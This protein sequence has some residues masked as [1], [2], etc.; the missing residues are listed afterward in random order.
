MARSEARR[1]IFENE[2]EIGRNKDCGNVRRIRLPRLLELVV[3]R[4]TEGGVG[5]EVVGGKISL[6][7]LGYGIEY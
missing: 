3:G 2:K 1:W 4:R 5:E 7:C 6:V